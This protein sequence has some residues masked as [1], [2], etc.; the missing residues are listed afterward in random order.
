LQGGFGDNG[1]YYGSFIESQRTS[2][3]GDG[4]NTHFG[5]IEKG[6]VSDTYARRLTI[7]YLGALYPVADN[8][9][10]LG[11]PSNLW[12]VVYAGTG[13]INT[14][15]ERE[16]QQI[17]PIDDAALRAWAKVEYCQFKF[18][19]AVEK[20]GDGARWH[21]GLIAQRVKEAFESEGLDAF[22]YGL[23]C[24]DK[25]DDEYEDVSKEETYTDEAGL[26][27]KRW[28]F[29]GEK[30]KVKDAG[31]K[32]GIRYE[33]ALTLECAYLRSKLK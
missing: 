18:N 6:A 22:Y 24:F 7:N 17:K 27:Q 14:S 8:S 13:T 29:T 5:F 25:W 10:A 33:E 9:Q 30:R 31:E 3:I 1:F 26:Q 28:V 23:L 12:S 16:K 20:K 11:G 4:V 15:D 21:V 19:D 32:Y 2:A